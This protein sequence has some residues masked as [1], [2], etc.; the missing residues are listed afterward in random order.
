[1]ASTLTHNS[2]FPLSALAWANT[3]GPTPYAPSPNLLQRPQAIAHSPEASFRLAVGSY[4]EDYSNQ[5]QVLGLSSSL[6]LTDADAPPT[7]ND[8][9]DFNVLAQAHHGYPAT[10]VAW[11]PSTS[12]PH[13][14]LKRGRSEL[15]A[16]SS[17]VLKIWEYA[18]SNNTQNTHNQGYV[19]HHSQP[20]TN[21]P[22]HSLSLVSQL[23]PKAPGT[24]APLTSF[25]WNETIPSRIVTC[26]IDTTCTVWDLDTRT[27]ITQLIAHDRE[28]YDVSWLPRS[29]DIFVSVGAD[30]SLRAFDLRSLEH[31]TILYET[32]SPTSSTTDTTKKHQQQ[33][34]QQQQRSSAPLLRLAFNPHDSNYLATFR[35]DSGEVNILDMRSPGAPVT[36]IRAHRQGVSS[37]AWKPDG[38]LLA[39]GS[40]DCAV[41]VWD[42]KGN[43][44]KDKGRGMSRQNSTS[45]NRASVMKESVLSHRGTSQVHN[46]AWSSYS[47]FYN[48][49]HPSTLYPSGGGAYG[50]DDW[51]AVASGNQVKVL[52]L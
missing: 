47:A 48:V 28:V 40:D 19:H 10:K 7:G 15:L 32:S 26:S 22:S 25:S 21:T 49:R 45:S 30:G 50:V 43:K 38:S 8:G 13:S 36:N 14:P 34:Q 16:S 42:I 29:S 51:I 20:I 11:E 37:M 52:K 35:H 18:E 44:D 6:P 9:G 39:T 31:S 27:A 41:H 23:T 46:L 33:Q 4:I 1:M 3:P 5:I 17:D 24:A 2:A 12:N